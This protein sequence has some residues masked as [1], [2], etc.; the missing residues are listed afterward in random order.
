MRKLRKLYDD[1][2]DLK[3]YRLTQKECFRVKEQLFKS[4]LDE[5][6]DISTKDALATMSNEKDKLILLMMRDDPS[7]ASMAGIDKSFADKEAR[8]NRRIAQATSRRENLTPFHSKPLLQQY[9]PTS[10]AANL[11]TIRLIMTLMLLQ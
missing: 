8:R 7:S 10:R 5:L 4:D 11:P 2:S 3:R 6:F 1:Y 9:T